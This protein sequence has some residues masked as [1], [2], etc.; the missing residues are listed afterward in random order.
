MKK[1]IKVIFFSLLIVFIA[2]IFAT[3][4]GIYSYSGVDERRNADVIIVLGAETDNGVVSPVYRE[5]INH[6]VRLYNEG[7]AKALIMTGGVADGNKVSDSEAAKNYAVSH[8]VPADSIFTE[9]RSTITQEN[10]QYAKEIMNEKKLDTAIIVSDPLH[11]KRAMLMAHDYGI[12]ACS[13]PTE[14]TMYRSIKTKL[15]FLAREE[16]F[17]IGYRLYRLFRR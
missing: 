11:M 1:H 6:A 7:Y 8:G 15:P 4:A 10:I 3:T 5:R 12:T 13:S 2:Y 17:Y 14:T 9:E 16:F